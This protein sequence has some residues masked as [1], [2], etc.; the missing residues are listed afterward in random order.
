[1]CID[2]A[3]PAWK[4]M[5]LRDPIAATAAAGH[6]YVHVLQG[7]L[8]CLSGEAR[9]RYRWI[10]EGM[11]EEVSWRA[12]VAAH[13]IG[14]SRIAREIHGSGAFDPN[15]QPL[16]AYER[17]GGRDPEYALWHL[18][19]RRLL[20]EAVATGSAPSKRP[21]M[22]LRRFCRRVGKGTPWRAAFR[23]SFGLTT[24]A[25]YTE[26]A[27]DRRPGSLNFGG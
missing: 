18:A 5:M 6:E 11:A 8:G 27:R 2:T 9:K 17:E 22:A 16:Q 7:E 10:A 1:M 23:R 26:F 12:L 14:G 19:T 3:S 25:F 24:D 20:R 4:W 13:R 21:E 15:L